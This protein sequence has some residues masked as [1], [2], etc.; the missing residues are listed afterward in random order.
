MPDSFTANY[1][2]AK[3]EVGGSRDQ[4][5]TKDNAN[6]D[7]VDGLL[8]ALN[9]TK[10]PYNPTTK[11]VNA[12]VYLLAEPVIGDP[13][14]NPAAGKTLAT[15]DW[16]NAAIVAA[17]A[18]ALPNT[19]IAMH[20][21]T[22]A[23]IPTGWVLCDG[24]NGTLDLRKAFIVGAGGNPPD[25]FYAP[26]QTGGALT[27]NHSGVT[28]DTAITVNQMPVHAHGV[29]DPTHT[30]GVYDPGH[31][32]SYTYVARVGGGGAGLYSPS[33]IIPSDQGATTGGSGTGVGIYANYTGITIQN[34]GG[35]AAHNH[36][37]AAA[38]S[39]PPFYALCYIQRLVV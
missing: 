7:A 35:G 21:G 5:G 8:K 15:R 12:G 24:N 4:W 17:L 19:I 14:T 6:W 31:T 9:D 32:H 20:K 1:N 33:G 27:H 38:D 23:S 16:V 3:P 26:G 36:P 18:T 37:I 25:G 30:H 13:A 10:V 29:N 2:F 11:F 22:V 28:G 39:R 34:Q